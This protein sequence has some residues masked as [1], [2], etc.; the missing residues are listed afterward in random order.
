MAHS[1]LVGNAE[2]R[3]VKVPDKG[4]V[5]AHVRNHDEILEKRE[6]SVDARL[7]KG[8]VAP[9]TVHRGGEGE[10][11]PTAEQH[12]PPDETLFVRILHLVYGETTNYDVEQ[13]KWRKIVSL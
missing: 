4:V 11:V 5:E 6:E 10:Q 3:T 7:A 1:W 8:V 13:L 2:P 12:F 9:V